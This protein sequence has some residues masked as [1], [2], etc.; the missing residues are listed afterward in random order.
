MLV[1]MLPHKSALFSS[2]EVAVAYAAKDF[3]HST[4]ECVERRSTNVQKVRHIA[5]LK[6]GAFCLNKS[7][8]IQMLL[9]KPGIENIVV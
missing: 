1:L 8:Y 7:L 6:F 2:M 9:T 3:A 5:T 4:G